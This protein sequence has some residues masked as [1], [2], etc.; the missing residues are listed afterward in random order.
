MAVFGFKILRQ[1]AGLRGRTEVRIDRG[2]LEVST[3]GGR[4]GAGRPRMRLDET[5][6]SVDWTELD[7]GTRLTRSSIRRLEVFELEEGFRLN[8][9]LDSGKTQRLLQTPDVD[10]ANALAELIGR[11][12]EVPFVAAAHVSAGNLE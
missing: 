9:I 2:S 7:H 6:L 5:G 3:R 10:L 12:L 11:E 4:A 8:A 1:Q